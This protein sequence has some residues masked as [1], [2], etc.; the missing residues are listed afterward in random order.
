MI[1][2][3]EMERIKKRG[4]VGLDK[5]TVK[6]L[7]AQLFYSKKFGIKINRARQI[8]DLE[9]DLNCRQAE[10]EKRDLWEYL[11]TK[12]IRPEERHPIKPADRLMNKKKR[13]GYIQKEFWPYFL[14][15]YMNN[16]ALP[17]IYT[18]SKSLLPLREG[19]EMRGDQ[20]ELE[21][22]EREETIIQIARELNVKKL[23]A[24]GMKKKDIDK[25]VADAIPEEKKK[26]AAGIQYVRK[27]LK[28][29]N[30]NLYPQ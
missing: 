15:W 16:H 23:L 24:D 20:K 10:K 1:S 29:Q 11:S 30:Y 14:E 27:L 28:S 13:Q 18:F 6:V 22:I 17:I 5:H 9:F 8:Y 12:F 25:L 26:K 7:E 2:V 21:R 4:Y 19:G 3:E